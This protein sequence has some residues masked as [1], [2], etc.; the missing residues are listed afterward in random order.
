MEA[1]DGT[2]R[3][4]LRSLA[5]PATFELTPLN[6]FSVSATVQVRKTRQ[7]SRR[8]NGPVPGSGAS[9]CYVAVSAA[10]SISHQWQA[11]PDAGLGPGWRL[12]LADGIRW[13]MQD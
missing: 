4:V 9:S 8:K 1:D 2:S 5:N 3:Q 11:L 6:K 10:A 12:Y 7:Q 13:E